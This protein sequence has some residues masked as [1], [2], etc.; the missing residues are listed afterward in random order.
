MEM[1]Q[2]FLDMVKSDIDRIDNVANA[3]I[4]EL[5]KLHRELDGKY[6]A[7]IKEWRAGMWGSNVESTQIYYTSI[8]DSRESLY[9]NLQMMKAKLQTFRFRMNSISTSETQSPQINVTTNVNITITFDEVR[10]KIEDMTALSQKETDEAIEKVNDLEA[11]SKE[12]ISRKSKWE[13]VKPIIAY[14]MD[15]GADLGIAILTLIVQMKLGM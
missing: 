9:E 14:A 3:S 1:P 10:R 13:K 11:I 15:K 8:Q 12:N 2:E 4:G 7:C 6:Q 5:L